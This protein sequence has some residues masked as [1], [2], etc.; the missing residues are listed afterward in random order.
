[1]LL[2]QDQDLPADLSI[3]ICSSCLKLI[4]INIEIRT[5]IS[6]EQHT[7]EK[8]LAA[9]LEVIDLLSRGS[10]ELKF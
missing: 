4:V 10:K 5:P 6:I 8:I 2:N 9:I 7:D 1:M 3:A